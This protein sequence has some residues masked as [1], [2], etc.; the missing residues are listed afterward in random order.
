[1]NNNN[2]FKSVIKNI[3]A[4]EDSKSNGIEVGIIIDGFY[5]DDT[6]TKIPG[7][8]VQIWGDRD[9]EYY[10]DGRLLRQV[11]FDLEGHVYRFSSS[12]APYSYFKAVPMNGNQYGGFTPC[13]IIELIRFRDWIISQ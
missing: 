13:E 5:L 2:I 6:Y 10:P 1:M 7:Y 12:S 11:A 9:D 3:E 8:V 4:L